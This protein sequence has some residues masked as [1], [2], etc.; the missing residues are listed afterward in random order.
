MSPTIS[1]ACL[2]FCLHIFRLMLSYF[3]LRLTYRHRR[4]STP[5]HE[6]MTINEHIHTGI[7]ANKVRF[8]NDN[9]L[10]IGIGGQYMVPTVIENLFLVPIAINDVVIAFISATNINFDISDEIYKEADDFRLA[11]AQLL[12]EEYSDDTTE[13]TDRELSIAK[14]LSFGFTTSDIAKSMNF[15]EGNVKLC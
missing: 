6:Y 7:K 2:D 5:F 1:G 11:C 10:Q 12:A 14:Y 13:L 3:L 8:F 15:S 4:L 9:R